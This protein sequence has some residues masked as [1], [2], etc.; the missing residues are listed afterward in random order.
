[1]AVWLFYMTIVS[2]VNY[3]YMNITY[4]CNYIYYCYCIEIF[5]LVNNKIAKL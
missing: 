1:M 4:T 2:G 5:V 3:M